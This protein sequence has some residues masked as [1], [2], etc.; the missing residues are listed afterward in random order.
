M[1][2]LYTTSQ[3]VA[4]ILLLL[5][6][7]RTAQ[8]Q[9]QY[10]H[11]RGIVLDDGSGNIITILPPSSGGNSGNFHIV[12]S[13]LPLAG[14][15]MTGAIAMGANNITNIGQMAIGSTTP[16]EDLTVGA[17]FGSNQTPIMVAGSATDAGSLFLGYSHPTVTANAR[18][19]GGGWHYNGNGAASMIDLNTGGLAVANAASGSAGGSITWTSRMALDASGNLSLPTGTLTVSGNATVNGIFI[20]TQ[21]GS[22]STGVGSSTTTSAANS[23]AFGFFANA[24]SGTDNTAVG[25]NALRNA[26]GAIVPNFNTAVGEIAGQIGVGTGGNNNTYLGYNA[27]ANTAVTNSTALG[28]GATV[29]TSNTIQLGN[30]SVTAVN[31]SGAVTA[32]GFSGPGTGLTGTAGSLNIGGNAAT[33][34]I[35]ANVTGTVAIAHGGT[36]ATTQATALTA[37]LP[38]QS[39]AT[40]GQVLTSNGS[41]ATWQAAS[42][43]NSSWISCY[44]APTEYYATEYDQIFGDGV[45]H[46]SYV[47]VG[48]A[49]L[50]IPTDC[51]IDAMYFYADVNYSGTANTVVF[52]LWV[53][54]SPTSMTTTLNW[55]ASAALGTIYSTSNTSAQTIHAGDV[56]ALV[57][58]ESDAVSGTGAAIHCCLH[59][60]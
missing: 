10:Y 51:T 12:G 56:V 2:S 59:A 43:G 11:T 19:D 8:A 44:S 14:G 36:G 54:G 20:G 28:S 5:I 33:A 48:E 21:G 30:A 35:A 52:T 26:G 38:T 49:G 46:G 15:T 58:T 4:A 16:I 41:T 9:S 47:N 39:G 25:V 55:A 17:G 31:T 27:N 57:M 22:Q 7:V 42:G 3:Y 18:Y 45:E 29:A 23:T 34:T 37:I 24:N 6:S 60:H 40:S 32:G 53:N 50:P 13:Y 1:K